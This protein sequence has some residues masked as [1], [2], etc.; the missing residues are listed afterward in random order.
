MNP[1]YFG[2]IINFTLVKNDQVYVHPYLLLNLKNAWEVHWS[3]PDLLETNQNDVHYIT[4]IVKYCCLCERGCTTTLSLTNPRLLL[5]DL[6]FDRWYDV[7]ITAYSQFGVPAW[8]SRVLS[9][10]TAVHTSK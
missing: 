1:E 5:V 3:P 4:Y 10:H 7:N 2:I 8:S 9:F 6:Y